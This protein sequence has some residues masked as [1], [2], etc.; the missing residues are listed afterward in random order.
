MEATS[1]EAEIRTVSHACHLRLLV[2]DLRSRRKTQQEEKHRQPLQPRKRRRSRRQGELLIENHRAGAVRNKH[3]LR[4][5]LKKKGT[6]VSAM[7]TATPAT[8]RSC[9]ENE[10]RVGDDDERIRG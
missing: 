2:A 5:D 7:M 9:G 6:E 4:T 10:Q 1:T 3:A 8:T